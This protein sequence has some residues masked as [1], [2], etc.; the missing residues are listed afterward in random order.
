MTNS[1]SFKG[2]WF[3]PIDP[4]KKVAGIL[5]FNQEDG[6]E[7]ELI[8]QLS[9]ILDFNEIHSPEIILGIST[10]GKLITLYKN[11]EYFKSKS[12]PGF[13]ISKYNTQFILIGSHF[14]N[15]KDLFFNSL[16]VDFSYLNEWVNQIGFENIESNFEK[17][18]SDIRY[19]KPQNIEFKISEH[20]NG[21]FEFSFNAPMHNFIHS[22]VVN[23]ITY[24]RLNSLSGMTFF[25]IMDAMW[26]F[27]NFLVLGVYEDVY[28]FSVLLTNSDN[29]EELNGVKYFTETKV[30]YK[31]KSAR[32]NNIRKHQNNFL[33]TYTHLNQNFELIIQ[34]WF[35]NKEK[36]NTIS[37]SLIENLLNNKF[38]E[39]SFLDIIRALETYH[40][41]FKKNELDSKENYSLK[42]QN[43]LDSIPKE[44]Y[45]W[46]K[47]LLAFSNEPSL[48]ERLKNIFELL[49]ESKVINTI[50]NPHEVILNTKNSRNYYTHFSVKL[51]NKALEGVELYR[52]TE[53]LQIVLF[54]LILNEIGFEIS[55]IDKMLEANRYKLYH[56][57][58]IV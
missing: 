55:Q 3:L 35:K 30:Y 24:L 23:Q 4:N 33:F 57:L 14:E 1:I 2:V 7:L 52:L 8:G 58:I 19:K 10:D 45:E 17:N 28:P 22:A 26:H 31:I 48:G 6:A 47:G 12:I 54:Y 29:F 34:N 46:L 5:S 53:K 39:N 15:E 27:N 36:L 40:R 13:G 21:S 51:K 56:H 16:I 18:T 9:S 20:L 25:E 49:S 11:Y 38:N 43:I 41:R 50:I 44:Y 42:L 37:V 32:N